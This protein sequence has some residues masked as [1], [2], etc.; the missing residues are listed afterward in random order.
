M[1]SITASGLWQ[2]TRGAGDLLTTLAG[3]LG[4]TLAWQP[5]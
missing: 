3:E 5:E 4:V 2:D 1:P